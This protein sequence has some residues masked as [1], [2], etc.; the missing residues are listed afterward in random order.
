MTRD[1]L[2]ESDMVINEL[3]YEK[4]FGLLL[5]TDDERNKLKSF[6]ILCNL[7]HSEEQRQKL[8][9]DNYFS[10]VFDTFNLSKIDNRTLEKLSWMATLICF[11]P[12][13]IQ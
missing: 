4:I 7:I 6:E 10:K 1:K 3:F 9:K 8:A 13:M 2:A 12:D 5:E 11:Y